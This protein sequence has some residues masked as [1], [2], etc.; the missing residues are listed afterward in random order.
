MAHGV[1][2]LQCCKHYTATFHSQI[3]RTIVTQVS[4]QHWQ[5]LLKTQRR[6][7]RFTGRRCYAECRHISAHW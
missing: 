1:D 6:S 7:L 2:M 3:R 5:L 4:R